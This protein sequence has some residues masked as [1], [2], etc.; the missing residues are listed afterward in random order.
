[1]K[2]PIL[3]SSLSAALAI[4]CAGDVLNVDDDPTTTTGTSSSS[5]DG[6]GDDLSDID[7]PCD[8]FEADGHPCVAAHSTVRILREAYDGPLYQLCK[9]EDTEPGPASCQGE[10]LDIFALGSGYADAAEQD[11]FCGSAGCSITIVYDQSGRDNDLEPAPPGSSKPTPG[12]PAD[13]LALPTMIN[14]HK[15]YGLRIDRGIGYRAGCDDCTTEIGNGIAQG[16]EAETI[17]MLTSQLDTNTGCCFDYGNASVTAANDG[18]GTVEAIY[19]GDG[20]IWGKGGGYGPWVMTD[21]ENGLFAG[22][23]A[24]SINGDIGNGGNDGIAEDGTVTGTPITPPDNGW[25]NPNNLTLDHDFVTAVLVGDTMDKNDGWGRFALYGGDAQSGAL[26]TMY[27]GIRPE[28]P[29]YVPMLKQGG[30]VLGIAGDN[31]NGASGRFYEGAMVSGAASRSTLDQVQ[32]AL[33]AAKYE[34]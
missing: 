16:D 3:I 21:L 30:I 11:E 25:D 9:T 34:E 8:L 4:S 1:M 33:V 6:D 17:Y 32:A 31:S 22:W 20:V 7:L 12:K 18:N 28:K 29:G 19:F 15:V 23:D 26:T 24:Q 13:A 5:G 10:A 2:H 14:G 27:D